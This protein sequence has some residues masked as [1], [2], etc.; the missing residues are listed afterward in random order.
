MPFVRNKHTIRLSAPSIP[1]AQPPP[2]KYP[3]C[4]RKKLLHPIHQAANLRSPDALR[5]TS[6]PRCGLRA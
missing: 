1:S 2:Q 3:S 5:L 4:R 6:R